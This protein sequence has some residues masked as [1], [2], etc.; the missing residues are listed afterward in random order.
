[1]F[2]IF[3]NFINLR[4]RRRMCFICV[5]M[6][7]S[8]ICHLSLIWG[9]SI[10]LYIIDN[11]RILNMCLNR[12]LQNSGTI[13]D[14]WTSTLSQLCKRLRF[15]RCSLPPFSCLPW[16]LH[17]WLKMIM[18]GLNTSLNTASVSIFKLFDDLFVKEPPGL[19]LI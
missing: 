3:F 17:I 18:L 15:Q 16:L 10:L 4:E 6:L 9:I 12:F 11:F 2:I 7:S 19:L 13:W 8:W 5:M 1:L 14:K